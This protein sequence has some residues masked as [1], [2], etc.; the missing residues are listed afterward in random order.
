MV[1]FSS[2]SFDAGDQ[3]RGNGCAVFLQLRPDARLRPQVQSTVRCLAKWPR[4]PKVASCANQGVLGRDTCKISEGS[5][6]FKEETK[7]QSKNMLF[8]IDCWMWLLAGTWTLVIHACSLSMLRLELI[9]A[10]SIPF[11]RG[12][13]NMNWPGCGKNYFSLNCNLQIFPAC[14]LSMIILLVIHSV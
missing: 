14:Y 11:L 10:Q 2:Q 3:R 6:L 4:W 8:S 13:L 7:H 5:D 1:D 9:F 12:D